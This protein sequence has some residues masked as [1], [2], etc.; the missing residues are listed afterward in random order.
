MKR[1]IIN[2]SLVLAV[3]LAACGSGVADSS[4]A[5]STSAAVAPGMAAAQSLS[6]EDGNA[7]E[8]PTVI[9]YCER[10]GGVYELRR[11]EYGTNNP[12]PLPLARYAGFCKY[13]AADTSRIYILAST[14]YTKLPTLAVLAYEA[15][16]PTGSCQGNPASCYCTLLGGSDQFGGT[17]LAGGGWVLKNSVDPSLEACIFPD[18]SSIDSWGLAYHAHSI[19]RGIDLT[20]V[21]RYHQN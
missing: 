4:F 13:T 21:V 17:S 6:Q 10:T 18:M 1:S 8:A 9:N 2:W 7:V 20:K 15:K 12:H 11:A 19:I 16:V 5:G 3:S 14:L